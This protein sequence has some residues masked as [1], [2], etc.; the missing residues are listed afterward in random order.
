MGKGKRESEK[1][2]LMFEI[3]QNGI[4]VAL[5]VWL[6]SVAAAVLAFEAGS[7]KL[8]KKL[9]IWL[10]IDTIITLLLIANFCWFFR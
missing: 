8:W 5:I 10:G 9:S 6:A 7:W 2:E 3:C 1:G 4:T